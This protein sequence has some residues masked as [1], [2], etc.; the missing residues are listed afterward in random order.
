MTPGAFRQAL[1]RAR[2]AF[3]GHLIQEVVASLENPSEGAMEEELAE[4]QLL[5]YC[6]PYLRNH[7]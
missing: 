7:N 4:L 6:R 1:Q 3:T 5:E 2:R